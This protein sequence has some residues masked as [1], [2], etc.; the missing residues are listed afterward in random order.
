MAWA[1]GHGRNGRVADALYAI[2]DN[3][4][5]TLG[6]LML[7]NGFNASLTLKIDMGASAVFAIIKD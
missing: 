1:G 6:R 4:C 2:L 7:F 5:R 3:L